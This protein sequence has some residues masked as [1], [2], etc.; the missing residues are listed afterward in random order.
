MTTHT[1]F[2]GKLQG[3]CESNIYDELF[4][5]ISVSLADWVTGRN[6]FQALPEGS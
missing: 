1:I 4:N 3:E 6:I 2:I 5:H